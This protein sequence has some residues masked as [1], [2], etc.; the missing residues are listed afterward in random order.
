MIQP[1]WQL[2]VGWREDQPIVLVKRRRGY[3]IVVVD[4]LTP[5]REVKRLLTGFAVVRFG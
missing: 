4:R 2:A 1:A 5:V 3:S